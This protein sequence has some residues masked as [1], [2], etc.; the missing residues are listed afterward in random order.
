MGGSNKI[1]NSDF[2]AALRVTVNELNHS[3]EQQSVEVPKD[4]YFTF[5]AQRKIMIFDPAS[6]DKLAVQLGEVKAI[7]EILFSAR[8]N[9]LD[10]I[11]REIVSTDDKNQSD[12]LLTKTVSTPMADLTPYEV[13]FRCFSAELAIV[14]ANLASSP[15]GFIVKAINVEPTS[16]AEEMPGGGL[17]P[18]GNPSPQNPNPYRYMQNDG[19]SRAPVRS[20]G[21]PPTA[22]PVTQSVAAP[23]SGKPQAFLTEKPFN[24][25][26]LIQVVKTKPLPAK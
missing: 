5:E 16:G 24:V 7:S 12:Y 10:Y 6:L 18:N 14:M 22:M 3:A 17:M 1:S 23:T 4:Y 13:R 25:T 9:S 26:L 8:V 19:R 21:G 15:Y 2:A 20:L 11:R